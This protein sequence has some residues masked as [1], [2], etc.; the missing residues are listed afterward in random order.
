MIL[1]FLAL[2]DAENRLAPRRLVILNSVGIMEPFN[3]SILCSWKVYPL[4]FVASIDSYIQTVQ[5]NVLIYNNGNPGLLGNY[6]EEEFMENNPAFSSLGLE[7][8]GRYSLDHIDW[9]LVDQYQL[10]NFQ[11]TISGHGLGRLYSPWSQHDAHN[12]EFQV[13]ATSGMEA[14][15]PDPGVGYHALEFPPSPQPPDPRVYSLESIPIRVARQ[16]VNEQITVYS[17]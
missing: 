13:N 16:D 7:I 2:R 15:A 14:F 12:S 9:G 6:Q 17:Q 3:G 10:Q 8:A 1:D 5:N 11:H 4:T